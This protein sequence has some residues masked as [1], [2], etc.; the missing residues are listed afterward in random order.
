VN[1]TARSRRSHAFADETHRRR[2]AEK[3]RRLIANDRPLAGC[4]VLEVGAGSGVISNYMAAYVPPTGSV[5]AVDVVDERVI[6]DGYRF[7]Q[8]M[9]ARLPFQDDS[10]DVVISNH[11][12]EHVGDRQQQRL[13]LSEIYR[14]LRPDGLLQFLY[15]IIPT[16]I[17]IAS[18][19]E[20]G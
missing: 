20:S 15:P 13:H 17:I 10:F 5:T 1:D 11:V 14:V 18:P 16:V 12:I 6:R 9:D 4:E 3:I 7:V 8:V 2:K 19:L